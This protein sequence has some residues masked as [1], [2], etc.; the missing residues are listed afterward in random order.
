MN[1]RPGFLLLLFFTIILSSCV[2]KKLTKQAYELE[3]A[4]MITEAADH[5]Y[6]ALL[7]K[8]NNVD[9]MIGLKRT[10][11]VVL[12]NK[13]NNFY[14]AYLNNQ[15]EL[16]VNDYLD[17]R[18]YEEN[19]GEL[20]V[21]LVFPQKYDEYYQEVKSTHLSEKYKQGYRLLQEERFREAAEVFRDIII[22][23]DDY[24]DVK[25]LYN[26]ARNEPD[27]RA[28]LEAMDQ[29]KYRMAY[30]LFNIILNRAGNYKNS[31]VL[32]AKAL[33]EGRVTV[34]LLPVKDLA[35]QP[36]LA[37]AIY[38]ELQSRLSRL[39]NPFIQLM[40][41][42]NPGKAK[43][44]LTCELQK[45]SARTGPLQTKRKKGFLKQEYKVKDPETGM[46][47]TRTKYHKV[48]YQEYEKENSVS[49]ILSYKMV[50]A[51]TK[52]VLV[53]ER[54]T[55]NEEDRLHYAEFKGGKGELLPGYWEYQNK[56]SE[57]DDIHDNYRA[58]SHLQQLL[59]NSRRIRGIESMLE[60]VIEDA[61]IN[62]AGK[63][64]SYNPE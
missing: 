63:V 46:E 3:Q 52:E 28:A 57:K 24:K 9:A 21:G 40:D 49:I 14:D 53:S 47:E 42:E 13:L 11:Q 25:A 29:D 60:E 55:A 61:T 31:E 16:A 23:E 15:V 18:E 39:R 43:A 5:Y 12:E 27:Y 48:Y 41:P 6:R 56:A 2:S 58:R 4:G 20:G 1:N 37:R 35:R 7:R 19:V 36:V 44:T 45:Y 34:E 30:D 62:I 32:K 51:N 10:G 33:E 22:L 38:S 17:A 59:N 26:E 8:N 50:S 64:N 54:F